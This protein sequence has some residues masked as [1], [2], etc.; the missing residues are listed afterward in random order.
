MEREES[1]AFQNGWTTLCKEGSPSSGEQLQTYED[2]DKH[3]LI[4][5]PVLMCFNH[6]TFEVPLP[7]GFIDWPVALLW[8]PF[9]IVHRKYEG[10]DSHDKKDQTH[11][12]LDMC[13]RS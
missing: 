4:L 7:E 11:Y 6:E 8:N 3:P 5:M 13:P 10:T 1:G 2:A 9:L 12:P